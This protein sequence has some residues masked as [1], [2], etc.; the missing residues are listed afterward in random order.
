M[1]RKGMRTD[2]LEK[3]MLGMWDL[4]KEIPRKKKKIQVF[5]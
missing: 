4:K 1:V 2:R 5:C 3:G